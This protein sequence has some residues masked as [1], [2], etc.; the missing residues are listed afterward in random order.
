LQRSSGQ[1]GYSSNSDR[2]GA[3]RRAIDPRNEVVTTHSERITGHAE[4]EVKILRNKLKVL[5]L[6]CDCSRFSGQR[7]G[8][9][10]RSRDFLCGVNEQIIA[11]ERIEDPPTGMIVGSM[12]ASPLRFGL[13]GGAQIGVSRVCGLST[14]LQEVGTP[15]DTVGTFVG[16]L[17][18]NSEQ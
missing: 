12:W 4:L 14:L 10:F 5:D 18:K 3:V 6:N 17:V 11:N 15:V 1:Y 7:T 9:G 2:A 16:G 13:G 8:N